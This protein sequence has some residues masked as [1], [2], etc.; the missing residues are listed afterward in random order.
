MKLQ[1][2]LAFNGNCQEAINFYKDVFDA[3][4]TT[5]M[6][7]KD[8]PEDV[9]CVPDEAKN[10]VMHATL[11]FQ[12]CLF[13]MSDTIDEANFVKG[14]NFSMSINVADVDEALAIFNSLK[15]GGM[16]FMPF[17]DAFWGGKFGMLVDKFG[18]QWMVSSE[19]KP[20]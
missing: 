18:V 6:H 12:D 8:A 3:Q 11:E 13:M 20:S 14:N 10:L 17:A 5:L 1:S 19:H 2:Y 9:M 7:F 15:E 4:V 16:E